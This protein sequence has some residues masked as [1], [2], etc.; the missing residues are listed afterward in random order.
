MKEIIFGDLNFSIVNSYRVMK[1]RIDSNAK[2]RLFGEFVANVE[3]Y[4]N[5]VGAEIEFIIE[6]KDFLAVKRID[7]ILNKEYGT[8][9][10]IANGSLRVWKE[11]D[12]Y[13]VH[14]ID[15]K[16]YQIDV[17]VIKVCFKKP[18]FFML[19]YSTYDKYLTMLKEISKKWG[20]IWSDG[21]VV[22]GKKKMAWM[23]TKNYSYFISFS[24]SKF[25]FYS[26]EKRKEDGYT[27]LIPSWQ[28][29]GKYKTIDNL[30]RELDSFFNYLEEYDLS[31]KKQ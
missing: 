28:T 31:L 17:H 25:A 14:G 19:E 15:E 16:Y 2:V 30:Y 6:D 24:K 10:Y 7:D 4:K 21:L 13:I 12:C 9:N 26:R 1:S 20:L 18:H 3:V 11:K 5:F 27:R 23:D 29:K 8:P 22:L